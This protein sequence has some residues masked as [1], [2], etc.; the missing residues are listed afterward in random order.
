MAARRWCLRRLQPLP[1][2]QSES[3]S[4]ASCLRP[5]YCTE[6]FLSQS[7][8]QFRS[9]CPFRQEHRRQIVAVA[10][11]ATLE[12]ALRGC[13][14]QGANKVNTGFAGNWGPGRSAHLL[15]APEHC[16]VHAAA[17]PLLALLALH[18]RHCPHR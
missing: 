11:A 7:E 6:L 13:M 4:R 9:S 2:T 10:N 12:Q 5:L 3:I 17:Q 1:V 15:A 16:C 14:E 18:C 8:T